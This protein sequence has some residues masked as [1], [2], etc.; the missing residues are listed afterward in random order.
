MSIKLL[1]ALV[2]LAVSGS[3]GQKVLSIEDPEQFNIA[4][5]ADLGKKNWYQFLVIY[6]IF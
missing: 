5:L 4:D 1:F 2:C 3:Q 6:F